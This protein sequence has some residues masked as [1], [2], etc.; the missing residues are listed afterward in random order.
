[1]PTYDHSELFSERWADRPGEMLTERDV[2][3]VDPDQYG[4][5]VAAHR[6]L[7]TALIAMDS[8]GVTTGPHRNQVR[9]VAQ[10]LGEHIRRYQQANRLPPPDVTP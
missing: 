6:S 10:F 3:I 8:T 4:A 2:A 1:V 7:R 5:A 9:T